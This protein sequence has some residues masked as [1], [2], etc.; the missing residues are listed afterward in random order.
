VEQAVRTTFNFSRR[1]VRAESDW[2]LAPGLSVTGRYSFERTELFDE[3]PSDQNPI[4]IDR[5]FPQVRISKFAGTFIRDT[6]DDVL[7]ASRGTFMI[8]DGDISARAIGSEVG[9]VQTY[10]QGFT[11]L[12][13]PTRRRTIAALGARLGVAR[14]FE[15]EVANPDGSID[16]VSDL[17][18]S[19][20][21]FA[22]GDTSVRGF[23]LDRLG[24]ADTI[25]PAGFPLGGNAVVIL[26]GE[27][28]VSLARALQ[29]VGFVDIGN[30]YRRASDLDLTDLRPTAGIGARIQIPF[31]PIRFDLGFNLDRRE[32]TPGTLERPYVF[33]ISLGQAF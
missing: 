13:L 4:L 21:F 31:A 8:A 19:E 15:R 26:N 27:L 14:G 23:S 5:Y 1:I 16:V 6:R 7:D 3:L 24:S 12:Q 33:H 9:F 10:V 11:Y 17:P 30:V 29:A 32:L 22:G 28:R 2:R 20:R 18:A 25:S